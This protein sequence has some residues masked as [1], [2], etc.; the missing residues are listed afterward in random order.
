MKVKAPKHIGSYIFLCWILQMLVNIV[1]PMCTTGKWSNRNITTKDLGYCAGV[2]N[3]RITLSLLATLLSFPDVLCLGLMLWA[4][5]SMIFILYRHKQRVQHIHRKNLSHRFTL[6]ARATWR[7]LVLVN[8]FVSFYT[9]SS[10]FQ[11][12]IA[13]FNNPS[14]LLVNI[15]ALVAACFPTVSPLLLTSHNVNVI[16]ALLCLCK[17]CKS[18]WSYQ[19]EIKLCFCTM[20]TC[21]ST[22]PHGAVS[23]IMEVTSQGNGAQDIKFCPIKNDE[24]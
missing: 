13:L 10:I 2:G 22:H 6:E 16:Q 9:L 7:L 21:V 14:W 3:N 11:V 18:Y 15:S 4:S 5:G 20:F 12:C 17:E 24:K 8:T 23:E 19:K 1:F